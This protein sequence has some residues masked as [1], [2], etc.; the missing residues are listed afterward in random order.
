MRLLLI[1]L[2]TCLALPAF[3]KNRLA[4]VI[5][6]DDYAEVR[7]LNKA[8]ADAES[9]AATLR[10]R[11]FTVLEATNVGRRAMNRKISDF[12]SR[13]EPGDTAL[14]FYAGHGVEIDGEN[15]LLPTDIVAP[16]NGQSDFVKSE[17]I[18]LSQMLDR[19]RS[20]GARLTIAIIDACRDNP[21][22]T[23]TG[24]SI[25]RTRGLGRITAPQGSFV[26]FSAGAGQ[27]ALDELTG[28]DPAKNSV[29]TRI[30]LDKLSQPGLELRS[31]MS[32]LRLE[33]RDLA[34]TVQHTQVPAYYDELIGEFYFYP[35]GLKLENPAPAAAETAD[36]M[37][38]DFELAREIGTAAALS[39]FLD[40]YAHRSDEFSYQMALQMQDGLTKAVSR[41]EES[42]PTPEAK[43][44]HEPTPAAMQSKQI[45]RDTQAAL[46]RLGCDAGQAD[47]VLGPRTKRAFKAYR[48]AS[49]STLGTDDLGTR[50]ALRELQ[51]KTGTV[52]P[53][54]TAVQDA[55][56]S[57][58]EA[59]SLIGTWK[60]KANCAL[61]INVTG[62]VRFTR[63]NATK[64]AGQV[65]DSLGQ[66]AK[67]EVF[68]NEGQLTGTDYFPGITVTWRGKLAADGQS[69]TASGSTG[70]AVYAWRAG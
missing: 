29:F 7:A 57:Q 51:G 11:G 39:A 17:S 40:R 10:D 8:V 52:C 65:T 47:G 37:R 61:V 18:A 2:L 6:N 32:D 59:H 55:P 5:G 19:V 1:L 31:M 4:L 33:V 23:T 34:R 49:G 27:L 24:R 54:S 20:T 15:Y 13:L 25:G 30:L 21:F 28:D 42:A 62:T 67:S 69:Y 22:E 12:T 70:C 43:E 48:T 60:Y 58:V 26:I 68:L 53:V 45:A 14:V 3:A 35:A 41:P 38:A 66:S 63:V 36:P 50:H 44:T 9:V 56:S 16:G 46:N 64:Y